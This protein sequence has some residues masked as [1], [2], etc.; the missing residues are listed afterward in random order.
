MVFDT[1]ETFPFR[2]TAAGY[3]NWFNTG[4]ET[5]GANGK[6]YNVYQVLVP[7]ASD[8]N[9]QKFRTFFLQPQAEYSS[10]S[11][12]QAEDFGGLSF[13]N[14]ASLAPEFVAYTRLTYGTSASYG[15]TGKVQLNGLSYLS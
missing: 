1:T 7:M 5:Q 13:G 9:S 6:F 12:A 11:A 14:F 15:T 10:L 3:I 4:T 8:S 2:N